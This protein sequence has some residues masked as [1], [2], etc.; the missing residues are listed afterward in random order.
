T[1]ALDVSVQASIID[2][3][4]E[5]QY[6]LDMTML[7]VTHNVAL[8]RHIAQRVAVLQTGRIVECGPVDQ[9]L[10]EPRHEYTRELLA[11]TPSLCRVAIW[12]RAAWSARPARP[13]PR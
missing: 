2:L 1:S 9:V 3:L 10:D 8:A 5:L 6:E 4:R 7:F 12:P 13:T 11:N